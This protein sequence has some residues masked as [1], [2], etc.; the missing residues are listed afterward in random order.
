VIA[1][2]RHAEERLKDLKSA[3]AAILELDVSADQAQLNSVM[4]QA[5]KIYGGIDVLVNNAAYIEAGMLEELDNKKILDG[6]QTNFLG[7]MG[8]ARAILPHFR[9]RKA[10]K[11][12]FMSSIAAY[13]GA[14]GATIY[15]ASKGALES[16][17]NCLREE[18][19]PFG[20]QCCIVIPGHYRT[21]IFSPS[22]FKFEKTKHPISEYEESKQALNAMITGFD[23]HQPGDPK[24]AM[25][26]LVD[27][28][29]GEGEAAG[30]L[31]PYKLPL[32]SDAI[33]IVRDELSK[34]LKACEEWEE[35]G[36][37]TAI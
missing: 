9:S 16:T 4:E 31:F 11:L 5:L 23:G 3:G 15:S 28:V 35:F 30:K 1:T 22:N 29:K 10:G 20:I 8:V 7:P 24:K 17:V 12:I 25:N 2:S 33:A 36:K 14:L 13:Y 32:G 6:L 26:L 21:K 37:D 19:T 18:V 34:T 27:V